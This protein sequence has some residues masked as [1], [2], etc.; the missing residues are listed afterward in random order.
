MALS[1]FVYGRADQLLM[2][3]HEV[4]VFETSQKR[5]LV[6]HFLLHQVGSIP[7]GFGDPSFPFKIGLDLHDQ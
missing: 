3:M 1:D 7:L 2:L 6:G 4:P 5:I